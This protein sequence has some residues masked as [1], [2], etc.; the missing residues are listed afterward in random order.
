MKLFVLLFLLFSLAAAHEESR[1]TFTSE[2]E[3]EKNYQSLISA[4]FYK[5][6]LHFFYSHD[7]LKIAYKIFQVKDA[8]AEI[9]I[10]SGRTEGMVKYQEFI[11][12]LNENGYNVYILDHRGQGYSQRLLADSQVGHVNDFLN[13]V[14]D[15]KYFVDKVVPRG[16][17]RILFAHSMG[18]AIAS[19]YLENYQ[20]DFDAAIL[21]SP[22]HQPSLLGEK[23]SGLACTLLENTQQETTGYIVGTG[24]YAKQL[25]SFEKNIFTHSKRRYQIMLDA[26]ERE[27]RT[28]IGGPSLNWLSQACLWSK[29]S[30]DMAEKIETSILLLQAEND[31]VVSA[32]AQRVFCEKLGRKCHLEIVKGAYHEIYIEKDAIR[33]KSLTKMLDF[34]IKT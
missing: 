27:D 21:S 3:L 14:V 4:F 2:E 18:G 11:Y 34:I 26:Y 28:K 6:K 19:L 5:H 20:K 15:V 13:Y 10:L 12:D 1:Y 24:P 9:V 30:I 25:K 33:T 32:S 31:K 8:K 7:K 29:I 17:K 22:M 16:K 23:F